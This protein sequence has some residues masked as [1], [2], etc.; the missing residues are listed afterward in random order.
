M[1]GKDR[2]EPAYSRREE[3]TVSPRPGESHDETLLNLKTLDLIY[4][5]HHEE[6][7]IMG[8]DQSFPWHPCLSLWLWEHNAGVAFSKQVRQWLLTLPF[9]APYYSF[10]LTEL[11]SS[12]SWGV[13]CG[14]S[15]ATACLPGFQDHLYCTPR[16]GSHSPVMFAFCVSIEHSQQRQ[17]KACHQHKLCVQPA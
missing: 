15:K 13:P 8:T 12:D 2:G 4:H 6:G 1:E 10:A 7:Q 5:T 17:R 14:S 16:G 3:G 11:W 9:W